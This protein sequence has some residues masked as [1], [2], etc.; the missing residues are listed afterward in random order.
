MSKQTDECQQLRKALAAAK[1]RLHSAP[2]RATLGE[3]TVEI[4]VESTDDAPI[5]EDIARI[6]QALR[7]AGC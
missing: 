7:E 5:Y 3:E 2:V 4:E 1:A 6:E